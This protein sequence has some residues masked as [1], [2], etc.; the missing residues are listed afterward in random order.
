M[1]NK[2]DK[3]RKREEPD[4]FEEIEPNKKKKKML[5]SGE[6]VNTIS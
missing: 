4:A 6:Q 3:K 2:A 5:E 1:N